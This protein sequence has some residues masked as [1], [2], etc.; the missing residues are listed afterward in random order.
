MPLEY[1][2][3]SLTVT[4]LPC[5]RLQ[6]CRYDGEGG[7]AGYLK[8]PP[9]QTIYVWNESGNPDVVLGEVGPDGGIWMDGWI[10]HGSER[11]VL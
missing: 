5:I 11:C 3:I 4:V 10:G 6:Q 8:F 1:I 2:Y 9:G 7:K